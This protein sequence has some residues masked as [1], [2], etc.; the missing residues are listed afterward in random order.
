MLEIGLEYMR[1][2]DPNA[3]VVRRGTRTVNGLPMRLQEVEVT[4]DDIQVVYYAHYYSDA[5]GTHQLVGWFT[6]NLAAAHRGTIESFVS[7]FWS[8]TTV[9]PAGDE[10]G[11]AQ[12]APPI[13]EARV[14][15]LMT[16]IKN[17]PNNGSAALEL[18]NTYFDAEHYVEAVP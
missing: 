11:T 16:V 10:T 13:D 6:S 1:E 15:S 8:P 14:Q 3:K 4:V 18:A 17:D 7:G 5:S 9:A 2:V 12:Q